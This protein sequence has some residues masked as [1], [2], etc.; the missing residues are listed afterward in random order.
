MSFC[1]IIIII[2]IFVDFFSNYKKYIKQITSEQ[3][4]IKDLNKIIKIQNKVYAYNQMKRK[5][6][7]VSVKRK[8]LKLTFITYIK[9]YYNQMKHIKTN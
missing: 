7:N 5:T 1:K 6:N 9:I 8:T 2:I 4:C 3:K